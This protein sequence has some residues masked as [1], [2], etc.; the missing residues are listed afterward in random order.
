MAYVSI[1]PWNGETLARYET[2]SA[3]A[4]KDR[5]AQ[6]EQ[7]F[8][9][10]SRSPIAD[11][12][13]ALNKLA[14]A[15][16]HQREKLAG[17]ITAEM[18]KPITE[19]RAEVDKCILCCRYYAEQAE[20]MLQ[21]KEISSPAKRSFVRID[22]AGTVL[23]LMPWNYP[24]WQVFR[25][26]VPNLA[27]G[28]AVLLRH[29]SGT[30]GCAQAME[31][32]FEPEAFPPGIFQNLYVEHEAVE[33]VIAHR[34]VTGVTL[35][36]SE[37]AGAAV[38]AVAGRYLKKSVLELGGSNAFLVLQGAD[39]EEAVAGA[40]QARMVNAGQS[41]IAAKRFI[42]EAPLY[43]AFAERFAQA[44]AEIS[45]GDPMLDETRLGPLARESFAET[46]QDQLKDSLRAGAVLLAGGG[47]SGARHEATLIGDVTPG[48]RAFDEETFGPLAALVRARDA[49][50][51]LELANQSRF[52]LGMS[53]YSGSEEQAL[54]L[55]ARADDGAVFLNSPVVSDPRHPF[56]GTKASGY[57]REL[58][59][60]G[61]LEFANIKTV[62]IR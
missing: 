17:L 50:H 20:Q 36:G 22:P 15:L 38:A 9:R 33:S 3:E 23:G 45:I 34:A 60:E 18:G 16:K 26:A 57:G 10:W 51:A 2:L 14:D 53:I 52:G 12:C 40:V 6:S 48:M 58:S 61:L 21:P 39:L 55:A 28:N 37:Q 1:N 29:A 24:F 19:S 43:Q 32:L 7:A 41:C 8:G 62:V 59:R 4:I 25:Y 54:S 31:L 11:R 13:Q 35:T 56:G 49:G 30:G 42:V 27:L 46:L 47:C 5:L 44:L